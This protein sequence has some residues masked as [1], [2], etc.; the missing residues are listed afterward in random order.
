[1]PRH[2][3]HVNRP[4]SLHLVSMFPKILH[5]PRQ[6][7]GITAHIDNFLWCHFYN[8]LEAEFVATFSRRIYND[9]IG[10]NV[11]LFILFRKNF[12]SFSD[13]EFYVIQAVALRIFSCVLDGRRN[14]LDS[15]DFSRFLGEE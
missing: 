13:E 2:S 7:R 3:K 10:F 15:A 8:R 14:N 11:V 6:S 9:D 4:D 5:I 12:L 1:M